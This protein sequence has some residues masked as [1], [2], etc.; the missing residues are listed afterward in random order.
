MEAGRRLAPSNGVSAGIKDD[1]VFTKPSIILSLIKTF[2]VDSG[3]LFF[4]PNL[5]AGPYL[6]NWGLFLFSFIRLSGCQ[7]VSGGVTRVDPWA[8]MRLLTAV[9]DG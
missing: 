7:V 8:T 4:T 3:H 9:A 6:L 1:N 5:L 2:W